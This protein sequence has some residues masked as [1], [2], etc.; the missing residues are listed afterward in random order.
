MPAVA[1]KAET[2]IVNSPD[3]AGRGCN[4]ATTQAT[5]IGSGDV[6]ANSIGVV[7]AA[8]AMKTHAGP[9]CPDHT[10]TL[11][12]YSP[13]VYA[14]FLNIGRKD[15][16]Y[17]IGGTG[18]DSPGLGDITHPIMTGSPNVFANS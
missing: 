16:V 13:N 18:P 8:D 14:N 7:R 15:D 12:T 4:S 6:F 2:D 1:R 11:S 3:G 9:G 5:K 10:P 17:K